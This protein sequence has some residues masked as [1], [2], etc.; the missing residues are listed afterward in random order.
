MWAAVFPV[1]AWGKNLYAYFGP[2]YGE[3]G[4]I[5]AMM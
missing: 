1:L 2:A 5:A 3:G 4:M